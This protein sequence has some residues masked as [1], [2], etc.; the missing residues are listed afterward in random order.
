MWFVCARLNICAH[1][2]ELLLLYQYFNS[3]YEFGILFKVLLD[4]TLW[5]P[6][7]SY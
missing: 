6:V 5:R 4:F 7:I 2:S 1:C 3:V